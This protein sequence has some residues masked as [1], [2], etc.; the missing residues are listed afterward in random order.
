MNK[1]VVLVNSGDRDLK[2]SSNLDS[3]EGGKFMLGIWGLY[4]TTGGPYLFETIQKSCSYFI[5]SH[6]PVDNLQKGYSIAECSGVQYGL[7]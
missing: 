1:Q 5:P 6:Y 7:V 2:K 4:V 3:Q